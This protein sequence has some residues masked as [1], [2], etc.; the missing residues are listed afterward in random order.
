VGRLPPRYCA[1]VTSPVLPPSAPDVPGCSAGDVVAALEAR[2]PVHLAESWDAVGWVCGDP[3]AQVTRVLFAV[4]P[5][6]VV[7]AHAERIGA[8]LIVTHHPLF[9]TPVHG[10]AAV[11]PAGRLVHTLI[12]QGRAL[13]TAHTNADRAR[14]GVSDALADV[15]GVG[16]TVPLIPDDGDPDVGLGRVGT[17]PEPMTLGEFAERVATV[18]P[19]TASGIRIAGDRSTMIERVAVCGGSGESLAGAADAAG[20]DVFVTADAKHHRTM[21]HRGGGGCAIIDVA[22]WASEWPWLDRA[23]RLLRQ[24]LGNTVETVVSDHV[25]DPWSW[26]VPSTRRS[27]S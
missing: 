27:P 7:A 22:H 3:H 4:D 6:E 11:T 17:L 1:P 23:A 14:Q 18:L 15:L 8:D 10:I 5:T 26:H 2:Y 16:G 20:A 25:T 9:L 19:A 21:D 24:D 12:E 13:Y